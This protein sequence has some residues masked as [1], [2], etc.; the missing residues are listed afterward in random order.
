MSMKKRILSALLALCLTGSLAGTALAAGWQATPETAR[1][2]AR[3]VEDTP[4]APAAQ[5]DA[6][7]P[8]TAE[9]NGRVVVF[10]RLERMS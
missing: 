6:G 3:Q 9:T 4:A 1:A 5:P 10:G 2:A 7:Q 8:A